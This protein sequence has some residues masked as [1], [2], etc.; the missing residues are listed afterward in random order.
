MLSRFHKEDL[1]GWVSPRLHW[2]KVVLVANRSDNL[3]KLLL[4]DVRKQLG[5]AVLVE[6]Y[7][8]FVICLFVLLLN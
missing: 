8:Y 6:Q 1:I 4:D 2:L 3:D 5:S 7:P